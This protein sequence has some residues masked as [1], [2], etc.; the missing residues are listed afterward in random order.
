MTNYDKHMTA[1]RGWTAGAGGRAMDPKFTEHSDKEFQTIYN[2]AYTEGRK[3]RGAYAVESAK[4]YD[5]S[6]SP[7]RLQVLEKEV[8]P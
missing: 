3:V 7:L 5:V 4:K 6:L 1:F 2:E 8:Q